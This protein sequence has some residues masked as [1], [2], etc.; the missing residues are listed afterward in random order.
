MSPHA[1]EAT[2][3]PGDSKEERWRRRCR[4]RT[5]ARPRHRS[6]VDA[7]AGGSS[8]FLIVLLAL[9][10][11]PGGQRRT[12]LWDRDEPRYAV[13]VREMRERG[14]WIFPDFQRRAALSQADPDL[15]AD[16]AGNGLGGDNPFGVRLVSAVA[17]AATVLG[18]WWLGRRMFG[19]RGRLLAGLILATAPIVVVESKLAT[20]DATLAL[21]LF[22][23]QF[24]LWELGRR[25]SRGSRGCSGLC[26]S[27]AIL[28]KGPVGPA[29]IAFVVASGL[30]VRLAQSGAWK[31]LH[32]RHGLIGLA[33][34]TLP[35]SSRS[36]SR[37]E[38]SS[39]GSPSAG[40]SSTASRIR[41]GSARRFSRLLPGRV[42]PGLLPVVG[43]RSRRRWSG[44]GCAESPIPSLAFCWAG[45]IG[46][47]LLLECFQTKLIHYYLPA[48]PAC[49]S[50]V[51]A[52]R[53]DRRRGGEHQAPAA[54]AARDG[55]SGRDRAGRHRAAARRRP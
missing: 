54:R 11:E 34:L 23:C 24:C 45:S 2:V 19:P 32:W 20:T 42:G 37:R 10:L 8:R 7:V 13:C 4:R 22:G 55:Y 43:V 52:G 18:V 29:L 36:A 46:P 53:V 33:I 16:G 31:R 40:R 27:L 30:V 38:A 5:P 26:L 41:H 6:S 21:L 14:D 47:L 3:G 25:P 17:G 39:C 9:G 50:A 49:A 44:R 15:L 48:F 51:V 35:G 28:T 12:G 1:D